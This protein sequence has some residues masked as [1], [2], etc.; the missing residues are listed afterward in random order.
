M[1]VFLKEAHL[2]DTFACD[3]CGQVFPRISMH[4]HH[5]VKRAQGGKDTRA[6]IAVLDAHCHHALHQIEAAI[7]SEKK[8]L[9]VPDL[10]RQ[11]YP[12]NAK[13]REQCLYLAMTAAMGVDKEN[14]S[15]KATTDE[16]NAYSE[17][18]TEELVH[19]TPPAVPPH[20]RDAVNRLV[21]Q[22]KTPRGKPIGVGRYL[23]YLVEKDLKQRGMWKDPKQ[24]KVALPPPD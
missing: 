16:D 21:R 20:V 13:A 9:H 2:L 24:R 23:R 4:E 3:C 18:D 15:N 19:L 22:M 8:R 6:N 12:S 11:L 14:P 17:F 7:K 5:K 1:A 10:L